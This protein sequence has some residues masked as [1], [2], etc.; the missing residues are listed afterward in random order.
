MGGGLE[1]C[2]RQE[3]HDTAHLTAHLRLICTTVQ[4]DRLTLKIDTNQTTIERIGSYLPSLQS[5]VLS[6]S[7]IASIR[8][9]GTSLGHLLRLE[10]SQWCVSDR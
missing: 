9:L 5:L 3:L 2:F 1:L 4:V 7:R 10:L 8:D 6:N